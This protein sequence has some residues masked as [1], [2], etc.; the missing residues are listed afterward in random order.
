M[1]TK[2]TLPIL[3]TAL[4]L[5]LANVLVVSSWADEGEKKSDAGIQP[6][7][8]V[9]TAFH[10]AYP[11]ATINNASH[12]SK[13]GQTYIE[14]ESMDGNQRRDLLYLIDGTLY[15]IE[16]AVKVSDLPKEIVA[17]L[18][19]KFPQGK[20]QKAERITRGGIV[21]Y[22]VFLESGE[23][24][25]EVLLD[26]QGVIKSQTSA[27]DEDEEAESDEHDEVDDD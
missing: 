16:E 9:L 23:D 4:A 20:M 25:L 14:I 19:A 6:P 1:K 13:D 11:S 8:A 7:E 10:K 21:Q 3:V 17:T 15:E 12:E 24:N 2:Q 26:S 22:E 27:N 5:L 18:S